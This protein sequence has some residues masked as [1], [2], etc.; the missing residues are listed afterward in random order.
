MWV[1]GVLWTKI[2]GRGTH[3]ERLTTVQGK[4]EPEMRAISDEHS[5]VSSTFLL[6]SSQ[7]REGLT[8]ELRRWPGAMTLMNKAYLCQTAEQRH[9]T[10]RSYAVDIHSDAFTLPTV[11][12]A[13][14]YIPNYVNDLQTVLNY[15]A[16]AVQFQTIT[17][18]NAFKPSVKIDDR[19]DVF[20][21][22]SCVLCRY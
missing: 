10:E 7:K 14:L 13:S 4:S 15:S 6:D 18:E 5:K 11:A 3:E 2:E 9:I 8:S 19:Q 20:Y 22:I 1:A 21:Y 17:M 16:W 12:T